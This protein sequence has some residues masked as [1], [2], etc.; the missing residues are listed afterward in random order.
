[1]T[2]YRSVWNWMWLNPVDNKKKKSWKH[3][4]TFIFTKRRKGYKLVK[5]SKKDTTTNED[6]SIASWKE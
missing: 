5:G 6:E 4:E 2:I 3:R 1:M